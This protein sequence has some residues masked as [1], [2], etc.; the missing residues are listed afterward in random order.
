MLHEEVLLAIHA[1]LRIDALV[2]RM[3]PSA[4]FR[5]WST[6]LKGRLRMTTN[7]NMFISG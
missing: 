1:T 2:T 3:L 5:R 7:F 4:S 6:I